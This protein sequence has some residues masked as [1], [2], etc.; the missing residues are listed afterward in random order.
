MRRTV[1]VSFRPRPLRPITI[2]AKIWIRSLSPS[3]TRVWT[4][5]PSPTLNLVRSVLNCSFSIASIMLLIM[6]S[7]GPAGGRSFSVERAENARK[8]TCTL[9]S[10]GCALAPAN[11]TRLHSAPVAQLDRVTAS[12]AVGCAFEPRRA[13]FSGASQ[14]LSAGPSPGLPIPGSLN[15]LSQRFQPA[16]QILL[17]RHSDNLIAQ[18]PILEEEEL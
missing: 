11:Y 15:G 14:R 3:T 7:S 17:A 2:P 13:H 4:R 16:E 5:T 10:A 18:L 9:P 6:V 8:D 1:K 12:E